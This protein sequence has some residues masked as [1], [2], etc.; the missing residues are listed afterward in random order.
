[1]AYPRDHTLP[2]PVLVTF[3][4]Q[5]VTGKVAAY[6]REW[7]RREDR[8]LKLIPE[9]AHNANMDN[10]QAFNATLE[11]FLDKVERNAV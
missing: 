5:D 1:M 7:S 9:A 3:G 11:E 10:P 6:C 4:E 8:P 2:Q